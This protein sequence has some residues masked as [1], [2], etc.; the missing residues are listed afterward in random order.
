[1]N[2]NDEMNIDDGNKSTGL[3]QELLTFNIENVK[4]VVNKEDNQNKVSSLLFEGKFKNKMLKIKNK[5][6]ES[7]VNEN[8]ITIIKEYD[9]DY[10]S[11]DSLIKHCKICNQNIKILHKKEIIY[12]VKLGKLIKT[13]KI[14]HPTNWNKILT[15]NKICHSLQYLNFLIQLYNLFFKHKILYKTT[16]NLS[17]FKKNFSIIRQIA[18]NGEL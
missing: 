5:I 2:I 16:L 8:N 18:I 10:K 6:I 12:Y 13:I 9:I 14:M 17:F 3:T 4:G 7:L 11:L 1:M 15:Q